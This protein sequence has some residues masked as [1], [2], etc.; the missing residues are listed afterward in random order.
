MNA[1]LQPIK[2]T[3]KIGTFWTFAHLEFNWCLKCQD[4]FVFFSTYFKNINIIDFILWLYQSTS[5]Q[6]CLIL[7]IEFRRRSQQLWWFRFLLFSYWKSRC[8][9]S[10]GLQTFQLLPMGSLAILVIFIL[11]VGVYIHS[12]TLD[13][14][15]IANGKSC[16]SSYL[17]LG[18]NK[19]VE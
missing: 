18:K 17:I 10:M 11:E 16:D 2:A 12:G 9:S 14:S 8:T 15:I 6:I 1:F 13:F 7:I 19:N 3:N 5:P 4:L